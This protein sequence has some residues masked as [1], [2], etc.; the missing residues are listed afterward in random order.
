MINPKLRIKKS[1]RVWL[2]SVGVA[3]AAVLAV[4]GIVTVETGGVWL[5]LLAAILAVP[6]AIAIDNVEELP[7][8]Q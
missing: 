1:V 8:K 3:V 4:Y 2:Y 6:Q 5:T 7:E